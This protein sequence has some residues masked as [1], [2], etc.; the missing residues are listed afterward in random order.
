MTYI[1]RKPL[2]QILEATRHIWDRPETRPAVRENFKR[3]LDCRTPAL[4]GEWYASAKRSTR[5]V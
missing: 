2:K 3:M 5:S 1:D 4:G